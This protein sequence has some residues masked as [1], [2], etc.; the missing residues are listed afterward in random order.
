MERPKM[1]QLW[2]MMIYS[3]LAPWVISQF[4][5]RICMLP[6]LRVS[7]EGRFLFVCFL[8]T[9]VWTQVSVSV[10]LILSLSLFV[11]VL[12]RIAPLLADLRSGGRFHIYLVQNKLSSETGVQDKARVGEYPGCHTRHHYLAVREV[13]CVTVA[14]RQCLLWRGHPALNLLLKEKHH[15]PLI[16]LERKMNGESAWIWQ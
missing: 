12:H 14:F 6:S 2:V 10:C 3:V 5:V 15:C 11:C 9:W 4:P 8:S 1:H 13:S 7:W 16:L